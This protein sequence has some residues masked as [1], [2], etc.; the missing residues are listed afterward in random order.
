MQKFG[1]SGPQQVAIQVIANRAA[2]VQSF[3]SPWLAPVWTL[4]KAALQSEVCWVIVFS[5]M[6][7][8]AVRNG[9]LRLH[10][11]SVWQDK[12][13]NPY[14]EKEMQ[15]SQFYFYLNISQGSRRKKTQTSNRTRSGHNSQCWTLVFLSN[16]N[17]IEYLMVT[18]WGG[19]VGIKYKSLVTFSASMTE[20]T[21]WLR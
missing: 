6:E 18:F 13:K 17:V 15:F 21:K 2:N 9:K 1:S 3:S 11:I 8:C 12:K 10:S 5:C 16:S 19:G 7:T 4:F 14:F 20:D